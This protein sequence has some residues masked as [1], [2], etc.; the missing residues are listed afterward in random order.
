MERMT[1]IIFDRRS[2]TERLTA[3]PP[4]EEGECFDPAGR[5]RRHEMFDGEPT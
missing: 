4:T 2:V 3:L 1:K 5:A